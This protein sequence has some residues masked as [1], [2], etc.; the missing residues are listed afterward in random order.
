MDDTIMKGFPGLN[1]LGFG[2]GNRFKKKRE[3]AE[4]VV[5]GARRA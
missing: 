3:K 4:A 2:G 5:R 1:M